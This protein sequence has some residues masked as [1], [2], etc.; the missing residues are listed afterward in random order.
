MYRISWVIPSPAI[1]P[2]SAHSEPQTRRDQ[3]SRPH[4]NT[5]SVEILKSEFK[6]ICTE[7][8][9][10]AD[11]FSPQTNWKTKVLEKLW[12]CGQRRRAS[13]SECNQAWLW[14]E[15]TFL[16]DVRNQQDYGS[17]SCFHECCLLK[18]SRK[19]FSSAAKRLCQS[20]SLSLSFLHLQSICLCHGSLFVCA[21][22]SQLPEANPLF[23]L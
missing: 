5:P 23:P 6:Q 19:A 21:V 16:N 11:L 4:G 3:Q 17:A 22:S 20:F 14:I 1:H 13:K 7:S 18:K 9:L 12:M 15:E 8:V 2:V 10:S